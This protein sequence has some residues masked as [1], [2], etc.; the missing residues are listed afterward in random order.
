MQFN[1]KIMKD[2]RSMAQNMKK[3]RNGA[4][5]QLRLIGL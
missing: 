1:K 4:K 5:V 3:K 2:I